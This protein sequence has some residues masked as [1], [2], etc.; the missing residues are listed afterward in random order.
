M[1]TAANKCR[2]N[3]PLE[4]MFYLCKTYYLMMIWVD[5]KRIKLANMKK[6]FNS[7]D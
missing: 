2:N 7:D 5:F 1:K 6:E 3:L 4:G